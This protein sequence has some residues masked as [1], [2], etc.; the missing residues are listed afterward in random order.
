MDTAANLYSD[1]D[2]V[3]NIDHHTYADGVG[4]PN[5]YTDV[6]GNVLGVEYADGFT[7]MDAHGFGEPYTNIDADI[8]PHD[9]VHAFVYRNCNRDMDVVSDLDS[10]LYADL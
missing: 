5:G 10:D 9:D 2:L 7:D 4:D 8:H 3:V 6:D 1:K